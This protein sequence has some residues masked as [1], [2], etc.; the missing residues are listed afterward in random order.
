M[1]FMR[2]ITRLC[3]LSVFQCDWNT[4]TLKLITVV[5]YLEARQKKVVNNKVIMQE[6]KEVLMKVQKQS[7][8]HTKKRLGAQS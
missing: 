7:D 5:V 8:T 2:F 6:R 3:F 4:R 1:L